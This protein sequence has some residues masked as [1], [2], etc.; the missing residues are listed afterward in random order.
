[1][2]ESPPIPTIA[3]IKMGSLM[4]FLKKINPLKTVN[5]VRVEKIRQIKPVA[6]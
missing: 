2:I 6:K 5:N 4:G 3:P 1:M